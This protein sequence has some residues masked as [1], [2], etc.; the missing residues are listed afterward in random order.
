MGISEMGLRSE[1]GYIRDRDALA[2]L[3]LWDPVTLPVPVSGDVFLQELKFVY[4][5]V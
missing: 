3:L 2:L 1:S 4:S 5:F